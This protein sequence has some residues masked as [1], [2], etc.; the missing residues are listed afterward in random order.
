MA[1]KRVLLLGITGVLVEDVRGQL[2]SAEFELLGGTGIDEV[3]SA[4]AT[5][6]VDHVIIGAGIDLDARL[7]IVRHIFQA[8]DATTV[9]LKDRISGK[10]GFPAFVSSVLRGLD[11]YQP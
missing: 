2:Q 11:D 3:R 1:R 6:A 9:H 4:F 7:D 5:G 8:S 10:E